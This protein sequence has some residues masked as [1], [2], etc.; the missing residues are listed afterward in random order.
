M[1][2]DVDDD[3]LPMTMATMMLM[4]MIN[5]GDGKKEWGAAFDDDT[6]DADVD[7]NDDDDGTMTTMVLKR[8]KMMMLMITG[9]RGSG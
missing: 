6:V 5:E 1:V 4:Q 2:I 9:A 8:M 7:D 3:G